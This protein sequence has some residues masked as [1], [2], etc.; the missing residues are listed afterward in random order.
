MKTSSIIL[1]IALLFTSEL[2]S[3]NH[4]GSSPVFRAPVVC[5]ILQANNLN[6]KLWNNGIFNYGL[7]DTFRMGLIWPVTAPVTMT[8]DFS[9]G[10]WIGAKV[11]PQRELRLAAAIYNSHY[12]PGNIPVTGQVPPLSVCSDTIWKSY[13]VK[14]TD[15]SLVNGG[16]RIKIAGTKSYLVNYDS[17][18]NW[19]VSK[20]APY[21][22]VNN[23]TGYQPGWNSDRPGIGNSAARPDEISFAVFMDYSDCTNNI[24]QSEISLP[25]GTLPLGAEIHQIAFAF[26]C[27]GLKDM[28]FIK[29]RIINKSSSVWDSTYISIVDDGDINAPDDDLA[30]CDTA[31]QM[32]FIYNGTNFDSV[33]G[34]AP[35]ALGYRMLQSPLVYTGNPMDTAKLPY[36]NFIGYRLKGMMV[37]NTFLKNGSTCTGDPDDA[38]Y[39]YYYM[40]GLSG[41]GQPIYNP[42]TGQPSRFRYSGNACA[43]TGWINSSPNDIRQVI[44]SGPITMNSNDTQI[45]VAAVMVGRGSDNFQGV[46]RV[47]SLSDT[48][49]LSYDYNFLSCP[50]TIGINPISSVIPGKFSLSQNYPNPFNPVTNFG[51]RIADFGLVNLVIYDALGKEIQILVNENLHPGTYEVTWDAS[52]F[53]SGVYYYKLIAGEYRQTKKMVL[54]K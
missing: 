36:G 6:T 31:R 33:Y 24:H 45:I 26:N 18:A 47:Q 23:V 11:G 54:I 8:A 14:L 40:I 7:P 2:L 12:T 48:A 16:T 5:S 20:G 13:L 46:C 39:A 10:I 41:C 22:E 34:A 15:S 19:P 38:E 51:F 1:I 30:G 49:K 44:S 21:V 32:G 25:G 28:Y 53:S 9:S 27:A 50:L 52:N 4:N 3:E 42:N 43:R 35:P 17:W 29:W 37:Y